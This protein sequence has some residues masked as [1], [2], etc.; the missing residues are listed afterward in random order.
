MTLNQLIIQRMHIPDFI[1]MIHRSGYGLIVV[2]L[3]SGCGYAV[4]PPV[5]DAVVDINSPQQRKPAV[6]NSDVIF[7]QATTVTVGKG[8]TIYALSRRHKLSPRSIIAANGLRPPY[9]LTPGQKLTLPRG[10]EHKVIRG[11]TLSAIAG[12]YD[13]DFYELARINELK[14]PYLIKSGQIL[15]L[16]Q[17]FDN[18]GQEAQSPSRIKPITGTVIV[19]KKTVVAVKKTVRRKKT[20]S[21]R[22]IPPPPKST[23]KGFL[24]P[25]RGRIVSGF[26]AKA[27][28]YRNDGINIAARRGTIVRAS[29]NGT[30]A[31]AGNELRGF[32]NLLL[33]KHSGGWVS[34]YAHNAKLLVKRGQRVKKGQV[35]A[36]VGT[37]GSVTTPQLHFE[38]RRGR[39]AK[40]PR[41]Y[42][43]RGA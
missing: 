34:A 15:R 12:K 40:D 13:L 18:S 31:Y 25:V 17:M 26:G 24:W 42:L 8:D 14:P 39:R 43:K 33:I 23:G 4:W 5:G 27:K 2:V 6:T 16:P 20:Q 29:E 32:G 28:G 41:K 22:I 38:L 30:V 19:Q 7:T 21:R 1:N 11:E 37:S 36:T 3:L 35:I 9:L 10:K